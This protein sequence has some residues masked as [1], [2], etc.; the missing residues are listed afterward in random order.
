[1]KVTKSAL[2][3]A[4]SISATL[5]TTEAAVANIKDKNEAGADMNDSGMEY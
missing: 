3:N 2:A 5:L 1:M 4:V